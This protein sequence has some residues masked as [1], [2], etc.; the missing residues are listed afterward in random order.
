MFQSLA[1]EKSLRHGFINRCSA[2]SSRSI[3]GGKMGMYCRQQLMDIVSE[4]V[5]NNLAG[6]VGYP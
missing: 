6:Q 2:A 5:F 3:S 1:I 4:L